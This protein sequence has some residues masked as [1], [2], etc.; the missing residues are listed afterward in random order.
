M[1][2]ITSKPCQRNKPINQRSVKGRKHTVFAQEPRP[3]PGAPSSGRAGARDAL[4]SPYNPV[5]SRKNRLPR[6]SFPT[7]RRRDLR[8]SSIYFSGLL[9]QTGKGYAVVIPKKILRRAVD[10]H[11]LKRRVAEELRHQPSLALPP[12]LVIFPKASVLRLTTKELT[13]D[14]HNLLTATQVLR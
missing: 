13:A 11:R 14:L 2:C 3:R 7:N 6:S 12:A 1:L 5:F 10:R 9:P 4:A 8:I